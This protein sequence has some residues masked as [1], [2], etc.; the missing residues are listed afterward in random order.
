MLAFADRPLPRGPLR[1]YTPRTIASV[2]A[3]ATEIE[4]VRAQGYAVA[5]EEREPGLNAVAAPIGPPRTR[6][7]RSSRSR[8]RRR[9]SAAPRST[10]PSC[11]CSRERGRSRSRSGGRRASAVRRRV[12]SAILRSLL[13]P[14]PSSNVAR[15]WPQIF[16]TKSLHGIIRKLMEIDDK[17]DDLLDAFRRRAGMKRKKMSPE[18]R[19]YLE[20]KRK[21]WARNDAEV[22]AIFAR[23]E[24]RLS[25]PGRVPRPPSRTPAPA[26]VGLLGPDPRRSPPRRSPPL[27][28]SQEVRVTTL[29]PSVLRGRMTLTPRE[30]NLRRLQSTLPL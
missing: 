15:A 9:V 28:T 26:H 25:R 2:R 24:E 3:L 1:A 21:I 4:R 11:R 18:F 14:R 16:S 5:F 13:P 29:D 17:L 10:P 19:R 23:R 22:R 8:D 20:E 7:R 27:P 6:L 12:G 30:R